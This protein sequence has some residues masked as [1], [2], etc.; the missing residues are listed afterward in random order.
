MLGHQIVLEG[1]AVE[2]PRDGIPFRLRT[3]ATP[4]DGTP[5]QQLGLVGVAHWRAIE[6]LS[7]RIDHPDPR[8]LAKLRAEVKAV[9]LRLVVGTLAH[10]PFRRG[11]APPLVLED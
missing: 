6:L 1:D 9:M 5:T 4:A 3:W 11:A 10:D 8:A 2:L 7:P